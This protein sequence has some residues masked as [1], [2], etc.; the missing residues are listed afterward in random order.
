M[1]AILGPAQ[2]W[3][4]VVNL[5]WLHFQNKVS[6]FY[7]KSE[8]FAVFLVANTWTNLVTAESRAWVQS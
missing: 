8:Q 2:Y 4:Q 6:C 3:C 7:H 1:Y 5:D